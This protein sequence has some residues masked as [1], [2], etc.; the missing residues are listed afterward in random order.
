MMDLFHNLVN[1]VQQDIDS[2]EQGFW[3]YKD[4]LE[5]IDILRSIKAYG[6]TYFKNHN[7]VKNI[8]KLYKVEVN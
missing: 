6:D 3:D 4:G 8:A 1:L 2:E 5:T 7:Y